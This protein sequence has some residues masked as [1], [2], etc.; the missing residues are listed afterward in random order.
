MVLLKNGYNTRKAFCEDKGISA[1]LL[2]R[3]CKSVDG[4]GTNLDVKIGTLALIANGFGV[5][6]SEFISWGE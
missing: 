2:T 1:G 5:S 3:I 6:V 4:S